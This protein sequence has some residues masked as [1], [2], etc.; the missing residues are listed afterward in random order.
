MSFTV[1]ELSNA[2]VYV[3]GILQ[4][5]LLEVR[6]GLFVGNIPTR[7]RDDL[8]AFIVSERSKNMNAIMLAPSPK[9]EG[10][11]LVRTHGTNRR[12]P[13]DCDG[14][15]LVKYQKHFDSGDNQ[16]AF[17]GSRSAV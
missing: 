8:W 6:V 9:S 16:G 2:S 12:E 3:H 13:V 14:L 15:W 4:R 11:F 5:K 17:S 7:V 10:G 1:I